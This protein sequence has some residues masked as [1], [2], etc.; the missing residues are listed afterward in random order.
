MASWQSIQREMAESKNF[1]KVRRDKYKKLVKI[2]N[3]PLVVY[4]SAFMQPEKSP[5]MPLMALDFSD[6]DGFEEVLSGIKEE[7]VDILLHSPGG[8]A[9]ATESIVKIV[10]N[11]IKDVRFIITGSAKSAATILA[12]SGNSI[13]MTNAGEMGPID[14]QIRVRNRFAPAGSIIEQFEKAT[15]QIVETPEVL[16]AWIPILQEYA[17]SLLVECENYIELSEKLVKS[18]MS[19]YMFAESTKKETTKKI[20]NIAKYLTNEKTNLSHARRIDYEDLKKI[21]VKV[22]L[23]SDLGVKFSEALNEVHLALM[24]TLIFSNALKIFENSNDEA[25]ILN[26]PTPIPSPDA[27]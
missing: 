6:K 1:D 16:P 4:A 9:E 2:T 21:G 14:P 25:L 19:K 13:V 10:R 5:F 22:S 18:W 8:S 3:R 27:N 20:N 17:P 26:V 23:A 15:Q 12:L 7:N 11:N 24:Q